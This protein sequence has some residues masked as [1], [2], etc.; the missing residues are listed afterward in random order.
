MEEPLTTV[1]KDLWFIN[2]PSLPC[3]H[4]ISASVIRELSSGWQ[5][6]CKLPQAKIKDRQARLLTD[7][8]GW[9]SLV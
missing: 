7:S 3:F 4:C 8:R 5:L 6:T 9:N 1:D 2:D